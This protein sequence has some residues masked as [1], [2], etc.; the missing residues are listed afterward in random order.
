MSNAIVVPLNEMQQLAA[1]WRT[2]ITEMDAMVQQIAHDIASIHDSGKGLNEVRSRG[3]TVGS[4]HQQVM[5]QGMVVQKHVLDS[6][7]RFTQADQE[8]AGMVRSVQMQSITSML[9]AGGL[10]VPSSLG[11]ALSIVEKNSIDYLDWGMSITDKFIELV[12]DNKL[13]TEEGYKKASRIRTYTDIFKDTADG[14]IAGFMHKDLDGMYD[15]FASAVAVAEIAAIPAAVAAIGITVPEAIVV[16]IPIAIQS[17]SWGVGKLQE[18]LRNTSGLEVYAKTLEPIRQIYDLK[19]VFTELNKAFL[20]NRHRDF[21]EGGVLRVAESGKTDIF[22]QSVEFAKGAFGGLING[23]FRD[24]TDFTS[25]IIPNKAREMY[26]DSVA[27]HQKTVELITTS[28]LGKNMS[29]SQMNM[30]LAVMPIVSN[31][32]LGPVWSNALGL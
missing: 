22:S 1:Q 29:A 27:A 3:R 14:V 15:K 26:Q 17:A 9:K 13:I 2:T 10:I 7:Q 28:S 21:M 16:A 5:A 24:W 19:G 4:H 31:V 32:I 20:G 12:N 11:K 23:I 6:V 18:N 30:T 25:N 8:L